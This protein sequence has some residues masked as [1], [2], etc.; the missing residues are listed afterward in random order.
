MEGGPQVTLPDAFDTYRTHRL[1]GHPADRQESL[2][3]IE[4]GR[5]SR[6]ILRRITESPVG[7]G[8]VSMARRITR[9]LLADD[10][11]AVD[12]RAQQLA[13]DL[14]QLQRTVRAAAASGVDRAS[15]S[16]Q[17]EANR[18]NL[19]LLKVEVRAIDRTL[20]ELGMAFAPATGLAGAGTRFAELRDQVNA[21]GKRIRLLDQAMVHGSGLDTSP[22]G[23]VRS[24]ELESD[25]ELDLFDYVAFERRFR[26]DSD[27]VLKAQSDRYFERLATHPP[28]ID[29]GCGRGELAALL[30]QHDVE[31][32][33]VE[34][35]LGM[36]AEARSRGVDVRTTDGAS[37]LESCG[38]S[39]LGAIFSSHVA[40]HMPFDELLHLVHL[41]VEKLKPGG[42]FLAE[43][44]NPA[45]LIVLGNSFILDPTHLR[46]IHPALF[47]FVCETAGFRDVRLEFYSPA[48][49]YHIR[50]ID[51]GHEFSEL[52]SD[53]ERLNDVLFGPQEYAVIATKASAS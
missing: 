2:M 17:V 48:T 7:R 24:S 42:I 34:P 35:D 32:V 31:V 50:P 3:S 18:V 47:A 4:S 11:R 51:A 36:A 27:E 33:G 45:A 22:P 52:N 38:S 5:P 23:T 15:L 44:P 13:I 19:E 39:S 20:H 9:R 8:T 40:E 28:V 37:F 21:L 41:S 49:D 30:T 12:N 16:G 53:L 29:V 1:S 46:P 43:T 6:R 26:G 14:E 10:F 25:R